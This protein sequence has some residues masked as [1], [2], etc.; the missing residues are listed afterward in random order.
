MVGVIQ[1]HKHNFYIVL[2]YTNHIY[3]LLKPYNNQSYMPYKTRE[4][5]YLVFVKLS[6]TFLQ[7]IFFYGHLYCTLNLEPSLY[8]TSNIFNVR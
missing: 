1:G 4:V 6:D 2:H 7:T 3:L 5:V 8:V